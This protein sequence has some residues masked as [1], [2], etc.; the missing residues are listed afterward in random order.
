MQVAANGIRIEVEDSGPAHAPAVL[1]IMGLGM[2]LT[3]WPEAW[4]AALRQA[5]YRVLRFDNRDSGLS[6]LMDHMP[7]PNLIWAGIKHKLGWRQ[8]APY[9]LL[10]MAHDA[11]GVL[12]ALGISRAHVVG[13]SMGGMIA[14]RLALAAPER[15]LSLTSIMS[16]SGASDLPD[17][18]PAVLKQLYSPPPQPGLAGAVEHSLR[19]LQ[20][21]ASPAYPQSEAVL[22]E[23]I[24]RAMRRSQTT[25]GIGRQTLA[26]MADHS[27]AQALSGLHVPTLVLHGD[28]D[29]MVPLACGQDTACRIPGATLQVVPGMG[30]DLAP[31]VCQQ[32]LSSLL[33]FLARHTP[34]T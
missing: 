20:M 22:R 29:R 17:P 13:V 23:Q 15:V 30:H 9:T 3:A 25:T 2:Q 16:S 21:I 10:D 28:A 1:L 4:V 12:D 14:Q 11:L 32:L 7:M 24:E 8:R 27:R 6:T 18:D 33:P 31:G 5:G 26:V 19:F 34:L